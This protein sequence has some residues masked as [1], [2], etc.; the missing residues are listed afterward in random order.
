MVQYRIISKWFWWKQLWQLAKNSPSRT[1]SSPKIKV[2]SSD[3][4]KPS[5]SSQENV[6]SQQFQNGS[7]NHENAPQLNISF[8]KG[9]MP[10]TQFKNLICPHHSNARNYWHLHGVRRN[11]SLEEMVSKSQS[12]K[13]K[14]QLNLIRC[15][16]GPKTFYFDRNIRKQ[17]LALQIWT[18]NYFSKGQT[19]KKT[20]F[21]TTIANETILQI[22]EEG[23]MLSLTKT[24]S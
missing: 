10:S 9:G 23:Y 7:F 14:W 6:L 3:G 24:P 8:R 1:K 17:K 21:D 12:V 2:K 15:F 13:Q 5:F 19:K 22:T 4:P 16:S 11:K 18:K 20:N